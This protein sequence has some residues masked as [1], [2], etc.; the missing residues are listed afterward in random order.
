[1]EHVLIVDPDAVHAAGLMSA[2]Q[3]TGCEVAVHRSATNI[4]ELIRTFR[5]EIVIVVPNSPV[6]L[7]N[8]LASVDSAVEHLDCRP[9]IL[10]V[11]RWTPQGVGER[12]MCDRWNVQVL[13]EL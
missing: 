3:S 8:V 9:E 5:P 7:G 12:L 13:Y 4:L 6:T 2:L 1:M 10:C 11:L